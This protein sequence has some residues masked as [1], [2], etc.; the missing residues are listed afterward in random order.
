MGALFIAQAT[1]HDIGL[2]TQI[3][4]LLFMLLSSKG[5]AG[6]PAPAWSRWPPRCRRSA[7]SSRSWASR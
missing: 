3:G 5:A 6:S 2:A 4:L 7:R 1:G